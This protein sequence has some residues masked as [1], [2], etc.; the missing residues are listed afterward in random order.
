MDS[1]LTSVKKILG[2]DE[3]YEHF[4]ADI[5]MHINTILVV[6]KQMGIGPSEG[7]E[8]TSDAQTWSDFLGDDLQKYNEVKTYVSLRTR[9]IFD[10]PANS[11]AVEVMK[12]TIKEMEYRMYITANPDTTF[13]EK[14]I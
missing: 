8:I 10:P 9:L 1:I 11:T 2:I 7:F 14:R 4:D 5:I 6:L 3:A 13:S 12:E